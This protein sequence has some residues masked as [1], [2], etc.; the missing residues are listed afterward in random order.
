MVRDS[1]RP[2]GYASRC[3]QCLCECNT[4]K[5]DENRTRYNIE[6]QSKLAADPRIQ[7]LNAAR[8]RA[9]QQDVPFDLTLKDIIVPELCHVFGVPLVR[10]IGKVWDYSPTLDK[11]VPALGYVVGNIVVVSHLANRIKS[12]ATP[13][14]LTLVASFYSKRQSLLAN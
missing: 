7:L 4:A 11:I 14:Q 12:D 3:K 2:D 9:G 1:R 8:Y 6:R 13:E 5:R 10:G